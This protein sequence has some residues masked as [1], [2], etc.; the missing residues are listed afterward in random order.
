MADSDRRQDE[1]L[2]VV[3]TAYSEA[4]ADL[5]CQ[6]LAEADIVATY[7]RSIGGPQWGASGSRYVY[8]ELGD[9]DRAREALGTPG[10]LTEADLARLSQDAAAKEIAARQA[11]AERRGGAEA[12]PD[13]PR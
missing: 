2:E 10:G 7:Q 1:M 6:R 9:L 4:E 13:P 11:A 3:A 12:D 8:V 5:I